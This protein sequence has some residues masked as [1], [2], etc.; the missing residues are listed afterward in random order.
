MT[1]DIANQRIVCDWKCIFLQWIAG[2]IFLN[3]EY[4]KKHNKID[5]L[6]RLIPW[7][8]AGMQSSLRC[9]K[10]P[11]GSR[12]CHEAGRTTFQAF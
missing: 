8:G 5:G 7:Q 9:G 1:S 12:V 3:C 2:S 6:G 11:W 10:N 4:P